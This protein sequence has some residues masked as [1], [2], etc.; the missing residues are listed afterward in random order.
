MLQANPALSWRDVQDVLVHT[1]TKLDSS[2]ASWTRN[3]ANLFHSDRYG[4]G[5]VNAGAAV[6]WALNWD[7]STSHALFSKAVKVNAHIPTTVDGL[8]CSVAI[9]VSE[10]LFLSSVEHVV[11]YMT[12]IGHGNRGDI[13]ITLTS[14]M[15]TLSL[16]AWQTSEFNDNYEY[17]KF[18]T[19]R[20]WDE[21]PNGTWKFNV[22]DVKPNNASGNIS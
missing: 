8:T 5:L 1:S 21:P 11:V 9:E 13:K 14:P 2:S 4:F 22:A 10:T 16:L 20:N 19:V 12:T 6:Q 15:G 17:Y 7:G 3:G 18:M